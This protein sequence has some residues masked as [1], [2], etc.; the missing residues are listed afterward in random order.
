MTRTPRRRSARSLLSA[1]LL[2][3]GVLA[4]PASRARAQGEAAT[5]PLDPAAATA[6]VARSAVAKETVCRE[7]ID[8]TGDLSGRIATQK[9]SL[10]T[11]QARIVALEE[12]LSQTQEE[13]SR[14][15]GMEEKYAELLRD[16]EALQVQVE[17]KGKALESAKTEFL[18]LSSQVEQVDANIIEKNAQLFALRQADLVDPEQID[19]LVSEVEV[20]EETKRSLEEKRSDAEKA[21]KDAETDLVQLEDELATFVAEHETVQTNYRNASAEL[22]KYK[23]VLFSAISTFVLGLGIIA[24]VLFLQVQRRKQ[25]IRRTVVERMYTQ[26]ESAD[27]L[28]VMAIWDLIQ[29][30]AMLLGIRRLLFLSSATALLILLISLGVI[31]GLIWFGN[32]EVPSHF[33][34]DLDDAVIGLLAGIGGPVIALALM[35]QRAQSRFRDSIELCANLG[36]QEILRDSELK[37]E[38]IASICDMPGLDTLEGMDA[39]DGDDESG[40]GGDRPRKRLIKQRYSRRGKAEERAD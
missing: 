17:T 6:L 34:D 3:F 15:V 4:L 14:L 35:Y 11:K 28:E 32:T 16:R 31:V 36:L 8:S 27:A 20:A 29:Q 2:L 5:E 25:A 24:I 18:G 1:I 7:Y 12:S 40:D 22:R 19:E 26:K 9:K 21:T 33:I 10:E 39:E 38:M 23:G 37:D 30:D 13:L